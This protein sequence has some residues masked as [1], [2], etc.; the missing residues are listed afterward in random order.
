MTNR[1]P[2]DPYQ[3]PNL[4]RPA[5]DGMGTGTIAALVIAA[6]LVV[7]GIIYGVTSDRS[8]ST[9]TAPRMDTSAPSTTGQSDS[10][11]RPETPPAKQ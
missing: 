9:A 2:Y 1:D 7:G 6:V 10:S 5:T 3:N 8:S 11:R 4:G